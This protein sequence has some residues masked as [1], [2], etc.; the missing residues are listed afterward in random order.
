[1]FP[2]LMWYVWK[3]RNEK[4]FNGKNISPLDTLQ[5]AR[6][7]AETWRVA[8]AVDKLI[9][10]DEDQSAARARPEHTAQSKR[11]LCQVD[12]SWVEK[13]DWMGMGFV[14]L[15]ENV[16][17]LQGESCAPTTQSP[18]HA[19]AEGLSWAL[20]EV[21]D[22]GFDGINF[23]SDCQQ[24]VNLFNRNED[25][26]ALA[27]ELDDIKLHFKRFQESSLSFISRS[28]NLRAD[29]LAKGG[30]S[31]AHYY[32]VVDVLVRPRPALSVGLHDPE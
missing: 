16:V 3:A 31:R 26:P 7:E 9:L 28:I 1:M 17:I 5:L 10:I 12:A 24:L 8:Q 19:E 4:C 6:Q 21:Y 15:E 27:P 20:R 23:T 25:W 2:W 29:S 30:R 14:L 11:F 32:N 13:E 22:R 18:L